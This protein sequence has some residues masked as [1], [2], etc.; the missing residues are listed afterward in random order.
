MDRLEPAI[1][2][3][4]FRFDSRRA[5]ARALAIPEAV[6]NSLSRDELETACLKAVSYNASHQYRNCKDLYDFAAYRGVDV[7]SCYFEAAN[8]EL[9]PDKK[10][11]AQNTQAVST[12][13]QFSFKPFRN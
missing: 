2:L 7:A 9:F 11:T 13:I 10:E 3:L 4:C 12:S 1:N 6:V 8:P 5:L